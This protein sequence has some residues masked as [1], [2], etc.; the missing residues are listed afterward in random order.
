[1]TEQSSTGSTARPQPDPLVQAG[2]IRN[3]LERAQQLL[4]AGFVDG[5]DHFQIPDPAVIA[6][7]FAEFAGRAAAN[8]GRLAAA[9][10]ELWREHVSLWS[11]FARK[12]DGEAVEPLATPARDDRRFADAAWSEHPAYDYMKQAYLLNARWMQSAV[13]QVDDLDEETRRKVEFYTR[14]LIDACSPTNFVATNPKVMRE[15]LDSGGENLVRGLEH[16]VED[17]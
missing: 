17:L 11:A 5:E 1:M 7:A 9:Q 15:T 16:L 13:Q 14:Q 3:L 6:G 10:L 8:P 12:L 4:A 2:R